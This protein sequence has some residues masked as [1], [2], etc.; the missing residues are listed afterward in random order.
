MNNITHGYQPPG[1]YIIKPQQYSG[2][3][4]NNSTKSN[5]PIVEFLSSVEE[6][7]VFR[8]HSFPVCYIS[9]ES[10]HP[11][12]VRTGPTHW[13]EPVQELKKERDVERYPK[14]RM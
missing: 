7:G 4:E 10:T 11:L 6:S 13:R 12:L 8:R 9:F 2:D 5:G 1:D 14:P 3:E